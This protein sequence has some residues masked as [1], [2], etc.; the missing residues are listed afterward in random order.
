MTIWLVNSF[1]GIVALYLIKFKVVPSAN[2]WAYRIPK[3][4]I[5]VNL[6]C[7]GLYLVFSNELRWLGR[8]EK[9]P[10]LEKH[11]GA[12]GRLVYIVIGYLLLL[13]SIF[14]AYQIA[15]TWED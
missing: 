8:Y 9:K 2:I 6:I 5:C 3:I 14:M 1:L 11:F 4:F 10:Y 12:E 7:A 13:G 15:L